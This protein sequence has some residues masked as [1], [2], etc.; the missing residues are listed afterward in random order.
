MDVDVKAQAEADPA[1][2]FL[3]GLPDLGGAGTVLLLSRADVIRCLPG[4]DP[5]AVVRRTLVDH[6]A[7]RTVL[8]AEAYLRW[9]NTQGAY[10]R[11]ISM[12]AGV[13]PTEGPPSYGLKVINASVSNPA[14]GLERAGGVGLCFDPQTARIVAVV[15]IGLISAVRTAAVSAIGVAAIGY[16]E[17]P[18]LAVIGCGAQGGVHAF[19]LLD[20]M[21][22][23]R[24]VELFDVRGA[25]A[26]DLAGRLRRRRP[27]LRVTVHPEVAAAVAA[28]DVVVTT[29]TADSGYL[30]PERFRAGAL[31]VNVSLG[32]L[33]PEAL[34][35][36]GAL[37]VDDVDLVAQNPRRPLG[38]LMREG[39]IVA[40]HAAHGG[41]GTANDTTGATHGG[42]RAID[43][44]LGALVA[45]RVAAPAAPAA[46]ILPYAVLN[47]FGMGLFDVA[48]MTAVHRE[49]RR[50]ALG[51]PV[52]LG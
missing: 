33:T 8:S 47:P 27:E 11:S 49:A 7:G 10:T 24:R 18:S 12:P 22:A 9:S 39:R 17:A 14:I 48:L 19:L 36:A 13:L 26:E 38:S 46:P 35:A 50:L 31:V 41:T 16:G 30:G 32:D 34:L 29:T 5:V 37:Y 21:L 3:A 45:G 28:G 6:D 42:P 40:P 52:R 1:P 23:L 2:W 51:T 25:V 44:T 43:A 15:E 4:V 20:Q